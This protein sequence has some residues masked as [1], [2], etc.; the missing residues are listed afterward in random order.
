MV[1]IGEVVLAKFALPKLGYGKRKGQKN[2]LVT[3]AI[4]CVLV[5]QASRTGEHI[6]VKPNGDASRCRTV[7]RVPLGDRWDAEAVLGVR[8]TPRKPIPSKMTPST[9]EELIRAPLIGEDVEVKEPRE[10]RK[11]ILERRVAENRDGESGAGLP[12]PETGNTYE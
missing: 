8:A 9:G 10:L 3:R 5:G 4:R 2:K 1:E 6:V 12:R 11:K 7:F